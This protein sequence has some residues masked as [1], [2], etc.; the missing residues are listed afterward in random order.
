MKHGQEA[1]MFFVLVYGWR[2]AGH[3]QFNGPV[4]SRKMA[5]YRL[6]TAIGEP[7]LG[8]PGR[9]NCLRYGSS[10]L[11]AAEF[12]HKGD[13]ALGLAV[14]AFFDFGV[15]QVTMLV[16]QLMDARHEDAVGINEG[17]AVAED[18]L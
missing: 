4:S 1:Q 10:K 9:Q 7:K 15:G 6:P 11:L 8:L 17:V 18:G 14:E 12:F 16:Q 3:S 5:M 2:L 13:E